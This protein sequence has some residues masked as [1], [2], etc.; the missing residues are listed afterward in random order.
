MTGIRVAAAFIAAAC[1]LALAPLAEA[2]KPP[3]TDEINPLVIGHRGAAGYRPDHT[4]AGYA[5]AI[6][7]AR[8][9]S[10]PTSWRRRT[11]T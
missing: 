6:S 9:T 5:L 3:P 7:R 10:S 8:T 1:S 2:K 11:A 4:L